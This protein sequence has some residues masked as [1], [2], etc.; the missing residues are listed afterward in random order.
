LTKIYKYKKASNSNS[1]HLYKIINIVPFII[2]LLVM[3]TIPAFYHSFY[4]VF[5][6][7]LLT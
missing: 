6:N 1:I 2:S 7:Q 3:N 4:F 5:S